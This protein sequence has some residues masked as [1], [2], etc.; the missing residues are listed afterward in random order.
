MDITLYLKRWGSLKALFFGTLLFLLFSFVLSGKTSALTFNYTT[1]PMDNSTLQASFTMT[2]AGIQSFL[3]NEGSGL[4]S[5][6]DIENCGPTTGPNYTFYATY[7]HCGSSESAAQIVYDASQ[8]YGINPQVI[9]AMMQKEQSLITTPNPISSQLDYAMGYGCGDTSNGCT[10][11]GFF[12]QVDNGTWQLRADIDLID[13]ISYWGYSPSAYPCNGP[14]IF[15]SA[16]LQPG[17]DVTFYDSYGNAYTSFVLPNAATS[18]FYCYTPHVFPGSSSQY[19]SGYYW[20]VYYFSIWFGGSTAPYAFES[21]SSP[22]MYLFIDGYKVEVPN[23][24]ILQDYG[25]NPAAI[26]ILTPTQVNNIPSPTVSSNGMS[27]TIGSILQ[28]SGQSSTYLVTVGRKYLFTSTQQM[29]DF[30][31]SSS[32][33]SYVPQDF[34]DSITGTS[35][36]SNF[37]QL[38]T[39]NVFEVSN[40]QKQIIFS[41]STLQS[42]DPSVNY[43]PISYYIASLI[44]S[45]NPISS[46]P[47]LVGVPSGSVFLFDN[48]E[49]Y[50][51]PSINIYNCYGF[52]PTLGIPQYNL[53]DGSYISPVNT[54]MT[55][56]SC[57]VNNGTNA[58]LLNQT[59]KLSIP[60]NFLLGTDGLSMD[61]NLINI[62]NQLPSQLITQ[63]VKPDN[64]ATV[65]YLT[66]NSARIVPSLQTLALLGQP[67]V[68]TINSA[69]F[70]YL[71][72][73]GIILTNGQLVKGD[74]TGGVYMVSGN[75]LIA[76]KSSSD[77]FAFGQS[78]NNVMTIPQYLLN[79]D[80]PYNNVVVSNFIY[81]YGNSTPYLVDQ[82]GCYQLGASDLTNFN[83]SISQIESNMSYYPGQLFNLVNLASCKPASNYIIDTNNGTVYVLKN[84]TLYPFASWSSLVNYS[85]SSNPYIVPLSQSTI[86]YLSIGQTIY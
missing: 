12:N 20:F 27:P 34:L 11:S 42:L 7:Y 10:V 3:Q 22:T 24:G 36:L 26:E 73:S 84:G 41:Y 76:F 74:Q 65:Y 75:N 83:T 55:L 38:P 39:N 81:D 68:D 86:G 47:I 33:I 62:V 21:S 85:G 59:N 52:N 43:T 25:I 37:V 28:V 82:N 56:T 31:F 18:A 15:Y 46:S 4:A 29:A 71:P 30:G 54:T 45:G 72:V 48:N 50:G 1:Y 13:G 35:N 58:Y 69:Y 77:F 17:N 80:Y 44:P 40:D 63:A 8:A 32:Q 49:Y 64:S 57:L 79:Q 19:Y 51:I 61:Q 70:S 23:T 16:A 14:T 5:F 6:S 2:V 66:D 67:S 78:F 53:A 9:L 60:N